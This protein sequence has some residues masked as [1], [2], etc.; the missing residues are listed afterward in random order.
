VV[1]DTQ[2]R[3]GSA[4][5]TAAEAMPHLRFEILGPVRAWHHDTELDLGSPQQ[6]AV[7]AIL[8]LSA[9]RQV[10][11]EILIDAIWGQAPPRA[12]LGTVRTYVSRLRRCLDEVTGGRGTAIRW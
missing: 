5:Q 12:A 2:V 3:P 11:M 7:L 9:G 8:L 10:S 4:S 6:H 1:A